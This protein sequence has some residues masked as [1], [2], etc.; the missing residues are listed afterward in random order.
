MGGLGNQLFQLGAAVYLKDQGLEVYI[1][2]V[3]SYTNNSRENEVERL[4]E[5][6]NLRFLERNKYVL[7]C[8]K[9]KLLRRLYLF[10]L[11]PFTVFEKENFS[12]YS[13]LCATYQI[14]PDPIATA[15]HLGKM[16]VLQTLL[17]K[18]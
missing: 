1:D 13:Q 2:P 18:I 14:Q 5:Y 4:A 11:S 6:L 16:E 7:L 17:K 8:F 15:R 9:V 3:L 10:F 12:K